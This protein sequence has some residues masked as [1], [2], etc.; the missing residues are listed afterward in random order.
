[1]GQEKE[2]SSQGVDDQRA[3]MR[4]RYQWMLQSMTKFRFFFAG[5]VFAILSFTVQ[6]SIRPA[7]PLVNWLQGSAWVLLLMTGVLA[8]RD[9]GG[10]VTR[11][12]E[13]VFGGLKPCF[14]GVM[15]GLF[16]GAIILLAAARLIPT[17]R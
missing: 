9:A 10:F 3:R 7:S 15:W 14:R 5:L 12:T 13:D 17:S 4:M 1:M 16:V 6:F 2:P 11:Y 8:L